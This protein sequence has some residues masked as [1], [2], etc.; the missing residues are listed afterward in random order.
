[1]MLLNNQEPTFN[2][3][4]VVRETGLKPDTLRAWERRY[5]LPQPE[6]TLGGHRLYSQRDID[7]LKWLVAR[8]GEGMSI[9]RAVDLWHQLQAEGKNPLE[10]GLIKPDSV[11]RPSPMAVGQAISEV[12]QAWL[13]AC[14]AFDEQKAERV[15]AQAFALYS[16]ET[17]CF[18]LIMPALAEIGAGWY[19]GEITVHQEHFASALATRRLETLL[20]AT[21]N[22]TK[23]GRIIAGCPSGE[24]HIFAPLL[25][26]LI[27]RRLGRQVVYLG[28]NVPSVRL[29]S[30]IAGTNSAL[31]ILVAQQ[32]PSAVAMQ[33]MGLVLQKL[34]VPMAY[35]GQVFN[36]MPALRTRITGHFL[37]ERLD[38]AP[39]MVEQL[40]VSAPPIPTAEKISESYQQ[41]L[42]AYRRNQAHIEAEIWQTIDETNVLYQLLNL[43]LANRNLAQNITAALTFGDMTFMGN[44]WLWIKG[45]LNHQRIPNELLLFYLQAYHQAVNLHLGSVGQPIRLWFDELISKAPV[46]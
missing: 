6:R 25:L 42:T 3:K 17:V 1:M 10:T 26:T 19:E 29:E 13:S 37:G 45:L 12:R 24:D 34:G 33:E 39:E 27:L 14:L 2:L 40:L 43:N 18:E 46:A 35:G 7:T 30:T 9:S 36:L 15:L 31:V 4:V 22:P 32:L 16:P 41:A 5:G 44:D 23:T 20:A 28:A 38:M 21:P 8:Q 11:R